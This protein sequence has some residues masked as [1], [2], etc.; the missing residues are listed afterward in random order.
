MNVVVGVCVSAG[1]R[2]EQDLYIRLIDSVTKQV[3]HPCVWCI[4]HVTSE[5]RPIAVMRANEQALLAPRHLLLWA[6]NTVPFVA[7][8]EASRCEDSAIPIAL[9]DR[10]PPTL[11]HCRCFI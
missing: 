2:Q 11:Y 1:V 5:Y 3:S 7:R 6:E 4:A 8:F 9:I 10:G